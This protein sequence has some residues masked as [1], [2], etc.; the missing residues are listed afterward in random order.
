MHI[1]L[2]LPW[3]ERRN[4]DRR[5]CPLDKVAWKDIISIRKRK[6]MVI[7]KQVSIWKRAYA[8]LAKCWWLLYL[9][10]FLT[11]FAA[12]QRQS[13]RCSATPTWQPPLRN[14]PLRDAPMIDSK[15]QIPAPRFLYPS[16]LCA[17]ISAVCVSLSTAYEDP[18]GKAGDR[19]WLG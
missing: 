3:R 8:G 6:T 17:K 16:F 13:M 2:S 12:R 15:F 11:C 7:I 9:M 5:A 18:H 19:S 1:V 4:G 14:A 10:L